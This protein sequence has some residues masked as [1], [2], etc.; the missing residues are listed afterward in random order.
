MP[1]NGVSLALTDGVQP[2]LGVISPSHTPPYL[3]GSRRTRRLVQPGHRTVASEEPRRRRAAQANGGDTGGTPPPGG[4][5]D[6]TN[7]ADGG[8]WI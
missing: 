5:G 1:L 4:S 2:L 8:V 7:P 6:S 3:L